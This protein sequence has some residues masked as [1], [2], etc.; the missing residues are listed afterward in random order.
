MVRNI[1][2]YAA[3]LSVHPLPQAEACPGRRVSML[4]RLALVVPEALRQ[5][6][7]DIEVRVGATI[8]YEEMEAT[9]DRT[10]LTRML[11]HRAFAL[12]PD[13]VAQDREGRIRAL[14][15]ARP[16]RMRRAGLIGR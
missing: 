2:R 12:A 8:R 9:T 5:M 4:W 13:G 14:R 3:A 7:R 1:I 10:A 11:R 15:Q 6:G 16:R